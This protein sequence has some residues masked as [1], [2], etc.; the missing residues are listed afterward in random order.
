MSTAEEKLQKLDRILTLLDSNNV[1]TKTDFLDYFE[2]VVELV[3]GVQKQQSGAIDELERTYANLLRK[4]DSDYSARHQ[5]LSGKV[6]QVFV[7]EKMN[8]FG[9]NQQ[10]SL[11]EMKGMISDAVEMK[12]R[13]LDGRMMKIDEG[14][15]MSKKELA[16]YN[17]TLGVQV[18]Q[19][20]KDMDMNKLEHKEAMDELK[21]EMAKIK[22]L[23][24]NRPQGKG[25]GRAKSQVIRSV[26]L[27]SQVD[28]IVTTYTLEPDTVQVLFVWSSQFPV[29]LRPTI[30]FSF[31]GRTLTLESPVG[32]IQSGQTL[33]CLV[34][35]LFYP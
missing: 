15:K 8:E 33:T 12:L 1:L 18:D 27:T 13:D 32:V 11:G 9:E 14:D 3:V 5:E 10:K 17:K 21:K 28:G 19:K 24:T 30:D 34:E 16:I 35:S 23:L 22:D 31:A 20:I 2:K 6:N 26:D 4:V 29:I 7:G 25:V